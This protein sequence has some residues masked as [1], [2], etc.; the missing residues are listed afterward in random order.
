MAAERFGASTEGTSAAAGTGQVLYF[1]GYDALRAMPADA[2]KQWIMSM[3]N[4][5]GAQYVAVV[6]TAKS[7]HRGVGTVDPQVPHAS[8]Q[9]ARQE[10]LQEVFGDG[11][12]AAQGR[13]EGPGEL[14]AEEIL[15]LGPAERDHIPH[16]ILVWPRAS[17]RE[18]APRRNHLAR[19]VS[20]EMLHTELGLSTE[21]DVI[22]EIVAMAVHIQ[23]PRRQRA[24]RD[25]RAPTRAPF[26]SYSRQEHHPHR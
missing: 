17:C 15:P 22:Q 10:R 18:R 6:G 2:V 21:A 3:E 26:R 7:S 8:P 25:S 23:L 12:G 4:A 19:K 13:E 5:R 16:R 24:A 14:P 11:P 9:A 1:P 20:A